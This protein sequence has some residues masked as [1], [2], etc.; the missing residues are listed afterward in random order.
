M[1][2]KRPF[3]RGSWVGHG[4][5]FVQPRI[6]QTDHHSIFSPI[7][8]IFIKTKK[9]VPCNNIIGTIHTK[10]R[11]FSCFLPLMHWSLTGEPQSESSPRHCPTRTS[12][13]KEFYILTGRFDFDQC[14]FPRLYSTGLAS[15][16]QV[17]PSHV[18]LLTL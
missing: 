1:N 17:K 5:H 10:A 6:C 18:M 13:K 16:M 11:R 3:L 4:R 9:K 15:C 7:T 14:S 8:N 12:Q 2:L